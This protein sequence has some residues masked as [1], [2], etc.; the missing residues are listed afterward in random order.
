MGGKSSD[1]DSENYEDLLFKWLQNEGV[2][3]MFDIEKV[4]EK[5][6]RAE[7]T[8][9]EEDAPPSEVTPPAEET[10]LPMWLSDYSSHVPLIGILLACSPA[11]LNPVVDLEAQALMDSL[12]PGVRAQDEVRAAVQ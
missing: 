5:A 4:K 11:D 8:V 1:F 6:V 12:S 2:E 3:L 7:V 9:F 10:A